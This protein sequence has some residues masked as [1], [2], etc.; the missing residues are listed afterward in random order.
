MACIRVNESTIICT[1]KGLYRVKVGRRVFYF[2]WHNYLG[3][4]RTDREGKEIEQPTDENDP[5]WT[6]I[7]KFV[8]MTPEEKEQAL[9]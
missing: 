9:V 5:Y 6:A 7:D 4:L 1:T 3:P 2:E 8:N